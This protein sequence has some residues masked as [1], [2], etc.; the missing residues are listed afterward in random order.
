M[1]LDMYLGARF[2][3]EEVQVG[4]WRKA[5]AIHKWFVDNAQDGVDECQEAAVT[6]DQIQALLDTV[7]EVLADHSKAGELLPPEAGFFFGD[8]EVDDWYFD[9]LAS[10]KEI[11]TDVIANNGDWEIFYQS[12]W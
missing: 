3:G 10:T 7:N 9:D 2:K 8:T 4:Y 12:S 5:N 1:G 11:L 6:M